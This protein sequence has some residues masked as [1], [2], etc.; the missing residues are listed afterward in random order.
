MKVQRKESKKSGIWIRVQY[1]NILLGFAIWSAYMIAVI[2]LVP[3]VMK[4]LGADVTPDASL[5]EI[6]EFLLPWC[7]WQIPIVLLSV[8]N[9]F[10]FGRKLG[11]AARDGLHIDG[12]ILAWDSFDIITYTPASF[13]RRRLY[14]CSTHFDMKNG[15]MLDVEHFP[16]FGILAV[17][18]F[19]PHTKILLSGNGWFIVALFS[20][21]PIIMVGI[22]AFA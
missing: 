4:F 7:M 15:M 16:L 8:L 22:F 6:S 5:N 11:Y 9:T 21:L 2:I 13:S 3:Y 18:Y 1:V 14:F 10:F 19:A 17:K 12:K 20:L